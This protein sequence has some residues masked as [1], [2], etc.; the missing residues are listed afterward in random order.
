MLPQCMP[1]DTTTG[2][3]VRPISQPYAAFAL[4]S[5]PSEGHSSLVT[6][7][8]RHTCEIAPHSPRAYAACYVAKEATL[9][10]LGLAV[11][12]LAMFREEK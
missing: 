1:S 11:S 5:I 6:V 10:A 3:P 9:K 8:D 2:A 7:P 12:D 4:Q